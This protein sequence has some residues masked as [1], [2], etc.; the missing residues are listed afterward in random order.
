[1]KAS[2]L[3]QP[4]CTQPVHRQDFAGNTH[5][6]SLPFQEKN[7][8]VP[9]QDISDLDTR[10]PPA[11]QLP[12][13]AASKQHLRLVL[14][15]A[16]CPWLQWSRLALQKGRPHSYHQP[17]LLFWRFNS[18]IFLESAKYVDACWFPLII[19][20]TSVYVYLSIYP[21]LHLS[22]Y[23]SI[24]FD[25]WIRSFRSDPWAA[26]TTHEMLPLTDVVFLI[27]KKCQGTAPNVKQ[28]PPFA[29]RFLRTY[30]VQVNM[31][32]FP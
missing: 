12:L 16:R 26:P 6:F 9:D 19:I 5:M 17:M 15:E 8:R 27:V 32:L 28:S 24:Y 31:W 30:C 10:L 3:L 7:P 2:F 25:I 29:A 4:I 13:Y 22:I 1:M 14:K 20:H 23:L 21:S 18:P 11:P